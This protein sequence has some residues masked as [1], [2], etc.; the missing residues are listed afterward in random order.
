MRFTFNAYENMI[1][2]LLEN[3]YR[4]T[5]Y[6]HYAETDRPCIL[7]HDV[8]YSLRTAGSFA[9][10]EAGLLDGI[11]VKSTYFILVTSA[12]YNVYSTENRRILK[13]ILAKGHEIGLHFD[14]KAYAHQWDEERMKQEIRREARLLEEAVGHKISAVSMHRP[15]K[16]TLDMDLIPGGVF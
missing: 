1:A 14:E 13:N 2:S 3:G 6:G 8:D 4:I 15:S 12:F 9:D 16:E 10:F 5:D 11:G 7:R